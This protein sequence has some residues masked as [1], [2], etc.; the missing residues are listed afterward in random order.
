MTIAPRNTSADNLPPR[1][2]TLLLHDIASGD[3]HAS[4]QLVEAV[5][6]QLRAAA[7]RELS[8]ER[9][10]HTLSAT[11]LVHE[12]YLKLAGPR[13]VPWA[14][15]AHFYAAAAEAM[16]RILL[17][18]A[19]RRGRQKRGG[20]AKALSLDVDALSALHE[21]HDSEA[22]DAGPDAH[23]LDDAIA[24]LAQH[25]ARAAQVVRLK[26]YAGLQT[27]EV[28]LALSISE[29]TVKTDWAFARA[30]IA[31]QTGSA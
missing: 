21:P 5:Y 1:D 14:N 7:R 12:A 30:W 16:R 25:D 20:G 9:P 22:E 13:E 29:S 26:Y 24:A 6:E 28:A 15:R 31:K 27:S 19:K 11:A 3:A 2:I 4:A 8:H 10:N 17:D 18:S 23:A